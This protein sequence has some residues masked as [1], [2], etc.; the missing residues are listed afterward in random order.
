MAD[1]F[2]TLSVD[3][4]K[5]GIIRLESEDGLTGILAGMRA[6]EIV[7]RCNAFPDLLRAAEAALQDSERESTRC[8]LRDAISKATA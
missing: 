3:R 6:A 7:R 8:V 4:D 1:E 5:P 2:P